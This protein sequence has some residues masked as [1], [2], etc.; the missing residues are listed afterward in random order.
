MAKHISHK[1][2]YVLEEP[3]TFTIQGSSYEWKGNY[4]VVRHPRLIR[5]CSLDRPWVEN[6]TTFEEMQFFGKSAKAPSSSEIHELSHVISGLDEEYLQSGSI[7][8]NTRPFCKIDAEASHLYFKSQEKISRGTIFALNHER[9]FS[10]KSATSCLKLEN[11]WL[12]AANVPDSSP[13]HRKII[14]SIDSL[15]LI[16]GWNCHVD[17]CNSIHEKIAIFI[18]Q[19]EADRIC[20]QVELFIANM[21]KLTICTRSKPLY[22]LDA[23]FLAAERA[24]LS[25]RFILA[26]YSIF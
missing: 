20:K 22:I 23:A 8:K 3:A 4:W 24:E 1:M 10:I 9:D 13:L 18:L 5:E 16:A 14:S 11:I 15:F 17:N 2:L 25:S 26:E 19:C 12:F 6:S 21:P 7:V